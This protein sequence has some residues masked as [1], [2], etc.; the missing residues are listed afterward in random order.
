[1]DERDA[2][3]EVCQAIWPELTQGQEDPYL[4]N[5]VVDVELND[6][7]ELLFKEP[8]TVHG[9]GNVNYVSEKVKYLPPL[10]VAIALP[11]GYP[12]TAPPQVSISTTPSWLP[13]EK[14]QELE[15]LAFSLWKTG[16]SDI[17]YCY[18]ERIFEQPQDHFGYT[19]G[20]KIGSELRLSL[21]EFQAS[22]IKAAFDA[23]TIA[24]TVC[25]ERK[26]GAECY[27]LARCGHVFCKGCLHDFYTA[28]IQEGSVQSVTCP[29]PD[30][31][32]LSASGG[33]VQPSIPP[34][35]LLDMGMEPETV[36][37]YAYMKRKKAIDSDRSI[38]R[39]PRTW[40]DGSSRSKKY[41]PMKDIA[42]MRELDET[43][44]TESTSSDEAL[45]SKIAICDKCELTFCRRCKKTWHGDFAFCGTSEE[46][47]ADLASMEFIQQH[48]CE[49][50]SCGSAITKSSGCNHMVCFN[51][52]THFCYICG[53]WLEPGN[54]Y[55]HFNTL[56]T[57][58]YQQ[59]WVEE[60]LIER[61]TLVRRRVPDRAPNFDAQVNAILMEQL[62][63][64]DEQ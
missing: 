27:K 56:G 46:A 6:P 58:C 59:L 49:C 17:L 34:A 36:Q 11:S 53:T 28:M 14:L 61:K 3:I 15:D 42:E 9:E 32:I 62:R 16:T 23:S 13:R 51:C 31:H 55:P 2:E 30:C 45:N 20:I 57:Q 64:E 35:E 10:Q 47:A 21:L 22:V 29:S 37:R 24:C 41:P 1:M 39:C 43:T 40:C 63:L 26:S 4:L 52:R 25:L 12:E 33:K 5:L 54:P 44:T 48:S 18:I 38:V 8:E 60:D 50:P 7:L 19:S